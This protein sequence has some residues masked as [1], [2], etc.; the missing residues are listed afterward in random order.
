MLAFVGV[1]MLIKDLY[2][3]PTVASLIVIAGALLAGGLASV[4]WSDRTGTVPD[5]PETQKN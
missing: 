2:H 5:V 1:K 3:I 4:I